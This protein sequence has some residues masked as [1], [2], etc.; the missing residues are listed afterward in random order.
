MKKRGFFHHSNS[1]LSFS[2]QL[3]HWVLERKKGNCL[4]TALKQEDSCLLSIV[5]TQRLPLCASHS[6]ISP[7]SKRRAGKHPTAGGLAA[8]GMH[9][10]TIVTLLRCCLGDSAR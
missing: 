8:Q 9:Y 6:D 5:E 1:K 3:F 4:V 2:C 7:V 10:N